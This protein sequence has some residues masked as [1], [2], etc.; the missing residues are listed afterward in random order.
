M[1]DLTHP[2]AVTGFP[3]N[4]GPLRTFASTFDNITADLQNNL[5]IPYVGWE[6]RGRGFRSRFIIGCPSTNLILPARLTQP[7]VYAVGIL[8]PIIYGFRSDISEEARYTLKNAGLLV[9]G[10]VEYR[11][12]WSRTFGMDFWFEGSWLRIRGQGDVGLAGSSGSGLAALYGLLQIDFPRNV[13][14]GSGDA[15]SSLTMYTLGAG[16]SGTLR[17]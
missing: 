17:F 3:I 7:G 9:E 16:L 6:V 13:F 4:I 15:D 12:N 1:S 8:Y 11:W 14:S 5:T 10:Q 2:V